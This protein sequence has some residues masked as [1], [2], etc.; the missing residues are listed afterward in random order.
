MPRYIDVPVLARVTVHIED[1]NLSEEEAINKALIAANCIRM[2]VVD[3]E[4]DEECGDGVYVE[5]YMEYEAYKRIVEGNFYY[6]HISE[7]SVSEGEY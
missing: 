7:V 1:D 5:D 4:I 2:T 6:G 3:S